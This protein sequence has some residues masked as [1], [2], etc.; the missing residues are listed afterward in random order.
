MDEAR[1]LLIAACGSLARL[2]IRLIDLTYAR[3]KAPNGAWIMEEPDWRVEE[4]DPPSEW[5][6]ACAPRVGIKSVIHQIPLVQA[7][8]LAMVQAEGPIDRL[9]ACVILHHLSLSGTSWSSPIRRL[10]QRLGVDL[11]AD[12]WDATHG[13]S[14]NHAPFSKRTRTP[15]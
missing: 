2:Q 1:T 8:L 11:P 6:D 12:V 3:R 13:A 9:R 7:H 14:L 15:G 10:A 4:I 5:L